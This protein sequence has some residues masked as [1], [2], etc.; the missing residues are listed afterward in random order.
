MESL[1][2]DNFRG[3]SEQYI[4]IRDVNF[5]VGENSSGK[6][7]VLIAL[8]TISSQ[9][10]WF[11]S[12]F[13]SSD[14]QIYSFED[15]VSAESQDKSCFKIG[16][17]S[18]DIKFSYLFEFKNNNGKPIISSGIIKKD[19]VL[20]V[21]I[22]EKG[23]VK[24]KLDK[25]EGQILNKIKPLSQKEI[26]QL[27][28]EQTYSNILVPVM[29]LQICESVIKKRTVLEGMLPIKNFATIAPI[30]SKPK[31]TYDE[32]GT[33]ANSEG[34]HIPYAI[35]RIYNNKKPDFINNINSFGIQSGLFKKIDIKEYE[36]T[37]DAPFRMNFVLDKEPINVVNIGYG[38]SQVL[39][40]LYNIY[41][42]NS[43]VIT[44]QQP[45][46]HLHPRAQAAIGNVFFDLSIGKFKKKFIVE[47]HSDYII[48]RFRQ[49]QKKSHEKS[50]VH[51]LFF[52][53][54]KGI[55]RVFSISIDD[56][57]NYDN[58]QPEKFREFFINEELENLGL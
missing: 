29:L 37:D 46:V 52:L 50:Y 30:R 40:I 49:Q 17:F 58:D 10:F 23:Q 53:R 55:N 19:K 26:A 5:L 11:N 28:I 21:F 48:D 54:E 14:T 57:G 34:D 39:P 22:Y 38:V 16:Y 7:S 44:I 43:A 20:F 15:L 36:N 8:N 31:K 32:P 33:L 9:G 2:L 25:D 6:S 27:K 1:Y 56:N 35:R 45:E 12:E 41:A 24:Y 51:V 4:E 47:T 13:F 3:F 42:K 18:D